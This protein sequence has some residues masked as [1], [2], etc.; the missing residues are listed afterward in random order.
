MVPCVRRTATAATRA[1]LRRRVASVLGRGAVRIEGR[2]GRDDQALGAPAPWQ[3]SV[4]EAV[5]AEVLDAA[6]ADARARHPRRR[7]RSGRRRAS[8]SGRSDAMPPSRLSARCASGSMRATAGS[9]DPDGER[10]V[11]VDHEQQRCGNGQGVE[12]R[13][14]GGRG[15]D[16]GQRRRDRALRRSGAGRC[17]GWTATL[18]VASRFVSSMLPR[19]VFGTFRTEAGSPTSNAAAGAPEP[20]TAE[21]DA[22]A[23]ADAEGGALG[24][25]VAEAVGLALAEALGLGVA[26]AVGPGRCARGWIQRER[27]R[28]LGRSG[29]GS[30]GHRGEEEDPPEDQRRG[31]DTGQQTGDDR[32]SGPHAG[33]E[34][35][36]T[37]ASGRFGRASR[38]DAA[39]MADRP[40]RSGRASLPALLTAVRGDDPGGGP[41]HVHGPGPP[42]EPGPTRT[43]RP[44]GAVRSPTPTPLITLPPIG[45]AA[46]RRSAVAERRPP[47]RVATRVRIARPRHRPGRRQGPS[48]LS[49][50]QRRDVP[51]RPAAVGSRASARPGDLHLTPT[52]ATGCSCRCC[53]RRAKNQIAADRRG[54]DERRPAASCTR[55]PRSG[56]TSATSTTG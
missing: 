28:R 38:Y 9:R 47:N 12:R 30:T 33:A 24:L 2:I 6:D 56:A 1:R 32:Q 54:L 22:D 23:E 18:G 53:G 34:G 3:A 50:L 45:T 44:V 19:S 48:R 15:R 20:P 49:V 26:E 37:D 41:A 7:A 10:A 5:V 31:R 17:H 35:T 52:P 46:D 39:P 25:G 36:S 29:R 16:R 27:C 21:G 40:K 43:A 55:S 8:R 14:D 42:A 11:E 13:V 4:L 51:R